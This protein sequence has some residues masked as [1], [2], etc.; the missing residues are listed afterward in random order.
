MSISERVGLLGSATL[1]R[2]MS[3]IQG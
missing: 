1:R 2:V 3:L